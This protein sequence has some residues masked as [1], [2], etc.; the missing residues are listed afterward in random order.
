MNILDNQIQLPSPITIVPPVIV[1]KFKIIRAIDDPK[2]K[3]VNA[4]VDFG[5]GRSISFE[6]WNS[7][8]YDAVGQWTDEDLKNATINTLLN[9]YNK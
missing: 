9:F 6:V 1:D 7:Q 5:E 3:T 4:V 2:F 8:Q